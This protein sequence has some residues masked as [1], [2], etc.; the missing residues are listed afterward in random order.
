MTKE[1]WVTRIDIVA[2]AHRRKLVGDPLKAFE[3][4]AAENAAISFRD[5]GFAGDVPPCVQSWALAR[6]WTAQEAAESILQ[7]AAMTRGA[8]ELIREIRLTAKYRIQEAVD[9]AA[10]E[11]IFSEAVSCIKAIGSP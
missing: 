11:S 4:L 10:A 5:A 7:E 6:G 9:D 2:D 3:Y 1:Y 8:L